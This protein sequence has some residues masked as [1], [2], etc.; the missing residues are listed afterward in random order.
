M[1]VIAGFVEEAPQELHELLADIAKSQ[2]RLIPRIADMPAFYGNLNAFIHTPIDE[3]VESFGLVYVEAF[4]AGV[5]SIITLSGIAKEVAID[6]VNSMVV[7]YKDSAGIQKA[8]ET[9][10]SNKNL[11]EAISLNA[12]K[13]VSAFGMEKMCAQYVSLIKK[14]F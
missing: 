4:A 6:G 10:A 2:L 13:S 12:K 11:S 8:L 5:P 14:S 1:V 9:L 7:K 3:T